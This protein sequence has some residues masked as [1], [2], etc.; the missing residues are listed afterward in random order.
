MLIV[1]SAIANAGNNNQASP[2]A[3]T[4]TPNLFAGPVLGGTQDAFTAKYGQPSQDIGNLY[5][6]QNLQVDITSDTHLADGMLVGVP[7][8]QSWTMTMGTTQCAMFLPKDAVFVKS[9]PIVD[10]GTVYDGVAKVY[11]SQALG[12]V[13]ALDKFTDQ[14]HHQITSGTF[15]VAYTYHFD[16]AK[17]IWDKGQFLQCEIDL[18]IPDYLKTT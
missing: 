15:T 5:F 17:Q 13:F 1:I 16:Q 3:P 8:G 11:T 10:T 2:S 14:Q 6:Y 4:A 7:K 9:F 12:G 18:G